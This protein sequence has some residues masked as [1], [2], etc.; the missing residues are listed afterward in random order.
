MKSRRGIVV[1]LA[2]IA[3][4]GLLGFNLYKYVLP[5]VSAP[6]SLDVK[7]LATLL[8]TAEARLWRHK[9]VITTTDD[10]DTLTNME[11]T[12]RLRRLAEWAGR[13]HNVR[14]VLVAD[15]EPVLRARVRDRKVE[16][17]D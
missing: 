2:V 10:W 9:L 13:V 12:D 8:P 11:K 6:P 14:E 15:S 1:A 7:E 3:I 4:L 17:F 16:I 5:A